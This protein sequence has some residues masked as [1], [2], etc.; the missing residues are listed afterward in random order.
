[1]YFYFYFFSKPHTSEQ[2]KDILSILIYLQFLASPATISIS[3]KIRRKERKFKI[4]LICMEIWFWE[5]KVR[6]KSTIIG[7]NVQFKL[8]V[9]KTDDKHKI[10]AQICI[11]AV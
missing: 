8:V 4:H 1:M 11:S 9:Y 10:G 6:W 3:K 7:N 5:K 2:T